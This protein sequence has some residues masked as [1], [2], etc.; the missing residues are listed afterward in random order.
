MT[1]ERF[2]ELVEETEFTARSYSGRAMY[3][4]RCIAVEIGR[5]ETSEAFVAAMCMAVVETAEEDMMTSELE[6]LYRFMQ[7]TRQDNMGLDT[8]IYWPHVLDWPEG[9]DED[10]DED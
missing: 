1:S 2:L 9:R 10:D 7:N 8:I 4:A 3:G 5:D 6:H